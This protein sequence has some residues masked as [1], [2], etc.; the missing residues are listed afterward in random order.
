[1]QE[2]QVLLPDIGGSRSI[3]SGSSVPK[4]NLRFL[5]GRHL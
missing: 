5:V 4:D 3:G 2:T 1:V